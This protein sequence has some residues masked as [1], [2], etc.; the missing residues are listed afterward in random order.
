[1]PYFA[2]PHMGGQQL[3]I[4]SAASP[5]PFTVPPSVNV[6]NYGQPDM[7]GL[8]DN[9]KDMGDLIPTA[10]VIKNIPF[11]V[12]KEVLTNIMVELHLPQPYAFNYHFDNGVFRGLA[13]ANFQSP[14][15]TKH[16]I[17]SMNGLDIH[18]RKLRVEYKKMLPE[19]ER[20]RIEREKREKRGQLEE[21]HRGPAHQISISS[22]AAANNAARAPAPPPDR[23][24]VGRVP[25]MNDPITLRY[26]VQ[27]CMFIKDESQ[28]VLIFP[29][30][31]PPED[32]RLVHILAHNMGLEHT[33]IGEGDNRQI[34]V[35]RV[36]FN[37]GG[38][39][40]SAVQQLG[41]TIDGHPRGLS[42]AATYDFNDRQHHTNL[43]TINT[44]SQNLTIPSNSPDAHQHG[45]NG[46]RGVK[47]FADLRSVSPSPSSSHVSNGGPVSNHQPNGIHSAGGVG[48]FMSHYS[49]PADNNSFGHSLTAHNSGSSV[50]L[51]SAVDT[52]GLSALSSLGLGSSPFDTSSS[53]ALGS[54]RAVGAPVPGAIGSQRPSANGANGSRANPERQPR[55]PG[56]DWEGGF[57]RARSN[58][59]MHRSSDSSDNI[60][61][62]ASANSASRNG[63]GLY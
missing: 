23:N 30:D 56:G 63:N 11:N 37:N 18:G 40:A 10:I 44:R 39:H 48:G 17:E 54:G 7:R 15:D 49:S 28:E 52:S 43:N 2:P 31:T 6:Q 36:K 50:N 53:P 27:L 12:R 13:F 4:P 21:Q 38:A 34:H 51:S 62:S 61:S 26:Y 16:V 35:S 57:A 59:H 22:M 5:D 41:V 19:H 14:T 1:M 32:R 46:L 8:S 60:N 45:M 24:A 55:G 20:E 47:S 58:G 3:G 9:R 25:D 42:R 29:A 33:S